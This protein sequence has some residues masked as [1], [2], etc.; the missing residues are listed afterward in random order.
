MELNADA[1]GEVISL[2]LREKMV[3]LVCSVYEVSTA[4]EKHMS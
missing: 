2:I 3:L 1:D 4:G